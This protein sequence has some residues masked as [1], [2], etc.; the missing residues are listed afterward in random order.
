M[1]LDED[2]NVYVDGFNLYYGCLKGTAYRWLDLGALCARLLP[3]NEIHRIRY[4]TAKVGA[5]PGKPRDLVHQQ[6]YLRALSTLPT[7]GVHLGH[8]PTTTIR[9]ALAKPA[10][11]GPKTV[12]VSKTEEKGS[13]VNLATYLLVDAS[14]HDADGFVAIS[15]NSDLTEPTRIVCHELG[16]VVGILN[17]Q[18]HPSRAL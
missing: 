14:R 16:N 2:H 4:F 3:K 9:M 17:P 18:P 6:A 7:V 15:N 11:G 8:F 12:E 10:P 1:Y 13:V 5:R